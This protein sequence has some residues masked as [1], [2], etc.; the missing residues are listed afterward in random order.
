MNLL[1]SNYIF[2]KEI[3]LPL[4]KF[5]EHFSEEQLIAL[6]LQTTK[7]LLNSCAENKADEYIKSSAERW[8]NNQLPSIAKNQIVAEDITLV[9][10]IRRTNLQSFYFILYNRYK[11]CNENSE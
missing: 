1:S 3:K 11:Y 6:G 9:S 10:F 7:E 2:S 5:L 8:L 4:L